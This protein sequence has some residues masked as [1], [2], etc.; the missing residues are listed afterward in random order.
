MFVYKAISGDWNNAK[1]SLYSAAASEPGIHP[2]VLLFTILPKHRELW[3]IPGICHIA[4]GVL[5]CVCG[6][7]WW[8]G[9]ATWQRRQ[10]QVTSTQ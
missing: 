8:H 10:L 7:V 6:D 3:S 2:S 5:G 9:Y 1:G 4:H